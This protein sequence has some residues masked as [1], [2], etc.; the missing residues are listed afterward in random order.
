MSPVPGRTDETGRQSAAAAEEAS[1]AESTSVKATNGHGTAD[2][3][4]TNG[5]GAAQKNGGA[6]AGT[7][8][9]RTADPT[10]GSAAEPSPEAK[11][12]SAPKAVA[13]SSPEAVSD[14]ASESTTEARSD[15]EGSSSPAAD[16]STK[17][18]N[19]D[20]GD[21]RAPTPAGASQNSAENGGSAGDGGSAAS[22]VA[23]TAPVA[24]PL[25]PPDGQ[26]GA[27]K[28]PPSDSG[29]GEDEQAATG[30]QNGT[31]KEGTQDNERIEER[32]V[33]GK[34]AEANGNGESVDESECSTAAQSLETSTVQPSSDTDKGGTLPVA[35]A[36][37]EGQTS[38]D[39]LSSDD[40]REPLEAA[41]DRRSV[42]PATVATPPVAEGAD[43]APTS[44]EPPAVVQTSAASPAAGSQPKSPHSPTSAGA[45]PKER[46]QQEPQ[47]SGSGSSAKNGMTDTRSIW[48]VGSEEHLPGA[49]GGEE[50]GPAAS[51]ATVHST[52]RAIRV[53]KRGVS[54]RLRRPP[55]R[56][57]PAA[58]PAGRP[59]RPSRSA[60][61][62]LSQPAAEPRQET[63]AAGGF[64]RSLSFRRSAS[65]R[66]PL[67]R[68]DRQPRDQP[69]VGAEA[70]A[71]AGPFTPSAGPSAAGGD[72]ADG[73][74]AAMQHTDAAVPFQPTVDR[75]AFSDACATYEPPQK[76][77]GPAA[78]LAS[79]DKKEAQLKEELRSSYYPLD[80][81]SRHQLWANI[82]QMHGA[83]LGQNEEYESTVRQ[84]EGE[85]GPARRGQHQMPP[86]VH[87]FYMNRYALSERGV[88]SA[89]RVMAVLYYNNP[90]ITYAPSLYPTCCLLLHYM[91]EADTYNALSMM[92][93]NKKQ[94]YI[95]QTKRDFEISWKIL[96][97]LCRK[98][99]KTS[100][101]FLQQEARAGE[102]VD[103]V[104]ADWLAWLFCFLPFAHAVRLMD[105]YLMEG[106]K[107]LYRAAMALVLLVHKMASNNLGEWGNSFK[108]NTV[109]EVMEK[110]CTNMQLGPEK[111][112]KTMFGIRGFSRDSLTASYARVKAQ[113]KAGGGRL[114]FP[115]RRCNRTFSKQ[116]S[117]AGGLGMP[118]VMSQD[119]L[120]EASSTIGVKE[121][122]RLWENLP[123]RYALYTPLLIYTTDEHG[124][125]L[126]TFYQKVAT[127]EPT[128]LLLR[129]T[130]GAVFGA[131]CSVTW[132]MR[133]E[134]QE[135]GTRQRYFGTGETFLFTLRP[136]LKVYPWV[137]K[138]RQ[139]EDPELAG[140]SH[141]EQLFMAADNTMVTI[142]G[143]GG[144][145]IWLD[146]NLARGK[147]DACQTFA[148][149]PLTSTGSF[150][151]ACM[152]AFAFSPA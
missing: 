136:Q 41:R 119:E 93:R 134:T 50:A 34:S 24:G 51:W 13:E 73:L 40:N 85:L 18:D 6:A 36:K 87:S 141:S 135:D 29:G 23:D 82:C 80:H 42:S 111:L 65:W 130:E 43:S 16:R 4:G 94:G 116:Q 102:N 123:A 132:N 64:L 109:Q 30:T 38:T 152:E 58:E 46:Q 115:E 112:L 19:G 104:L 147:T 120:A 71:A 5:T 72:F 3:H 66:G 11:A 75:A 32:D 124:F 79:R 37:G 15:P 44:A 31:E 117:N 150:E 90:T 126:K 129:T 22:P 54:K 28:T 62:Q 95:V 128:V 149:P 67:R 17:T 92:L 83:T 52:V 35:S 12:E 121:L 133:N 56:D 26:S 7:G 49:V 143:G 107:V 86:F 103:H 33:R 110:F 76:H 55:S 145:A 21:R 127:F 14:L 77:V 139:A 125:S 74:E 27:D 131:Y 25:T 81:P 60:D 63:P 106:E 151:V 70:P 47:P 146:E 101:H 69:Q 68:A 137:G 2:G 108:E 96:I 88:W 148:N 99:A 105:C 98:H 20:H 78:D 140:L 8:A 57:Q 118:S 142:G 9:E 100:V 39:N 84:L 114:S 48:V 113:I 59:P 122:L 97:K 10:A 91:D 89:E 1:R 53:F 144:Q 61:R 45:K 138:V